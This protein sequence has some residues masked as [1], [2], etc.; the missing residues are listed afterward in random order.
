MG[1]ALP[2]LVASSGFEE[3]FVL[4]RQVVMGRVEVPY[5]WVYPK[6][7]LRNP[8]GVPLFEATVGFEVVF[9]TRYSLTIDLNRMSLTR[10]RCSL[11]S[12]S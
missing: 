3:P 5:H 8:A 11:V 7:V 6:E 12:R 1:A 4:D 10:E 9:V 2:V